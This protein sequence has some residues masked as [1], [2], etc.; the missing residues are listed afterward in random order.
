MSVSGWQRALGAVSGVALLVTGLSAQN[1]PGRKS[2]EQPQQAQGPKYLAGSW[3]FT[4]V[5]RE[6]PLTQGPRSGSVTFTPSADGRTITSRT[7]GKVDDTGAAYTEDATIGWEEATKRLTFKERLAAVEVQGTGDWSSPLA[8][9]YESQAVT[10][11]GES[12]RLRRTYSILSARSFSVAEE[13][14]VNGGPYQ[15]LGSGQ[16]VKSGF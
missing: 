14:S 12:L 13:I 5:G 4:W 16:F 11:G 2:P 15:R 8:I 7:Q 6:S 9:A 10:V 3:N 1:L